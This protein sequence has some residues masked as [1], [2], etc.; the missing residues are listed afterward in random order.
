MGTH[1]QCQAVPLVNPASP[2][3]GTGMEELIARGAGR[4]I[5]AP[6]DGVVKY[7]DAEKLVYL[8]KSGKEY[9]YDIKKFERTNKDTSFSQTAL[10]SN[11][12]QVKKG[13]VL[14]DGPTTKGGE[15][16]IGQNLLVAY[17]AYEGLGYED[18]IVVSERVLHKDLLMSVVIEEYKADVVNTK[19]GP[20]EITR[21]IPNVREEIL[22]N[23]DKKGIAVVG[24]H[25]KGGDILVGKVAPKGE[26]ELTAEE[27]L[28]KAIFG[29]KA[30]EVQDTSLTV[31]YGKG[32]TV[33]D[34]R[35]LT[36]KDGAELEPGVL[37]RIIVKLA[38]LRK[39]MVGD[40]LSGRHG[41]KG[42]VSKIVSVEDMPYLA[43]GTPVDIIISPL[44]VISR[45]NLGQLFETYLGMAAR[46]LDRRLA[47]PVFD[48]I[49][50]EVLISEMQK[51]GLPA[52]GK[53]T[54]YNGK[55]GLP[56][57]N[58]IV[59]GYEYILKLAHMVKDKIHAR[60]TGPYSL[61]SQQP[62]GGKAQMGGQRFGEMEVWALEAHRAAY[63]LQEMLTI[64]SDDISGRNKAFEAIIKG[65]EIPTPGIPES[66]KVLVKELNAL[67]LEVEMLK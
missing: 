33:I 49:P 15:I 67:G 57:E 19:L 41:N 28:L 4:T 55:T 30:K 9:K 7:V 10:V 13:N 21:D 44:S 27:R 38:E 17:M 26:K 56:F 62:L 25:V 3:I 45:M 47:I 18:A 64:K 66:F 39:I 35:T 40:K 32:G 37:Q 23:L 14:I 11:L 50:E 58:K 16:A 36:D 53:F 20:E 8:G 54:L 61:V 22:A 2:L 42:V 5:I 31:P 24:S 52:E 48:R 59:V 43:D 12:Q 65:L 46:E 60:S 63:I 1:M 34:I 6:E 29:E 51:A